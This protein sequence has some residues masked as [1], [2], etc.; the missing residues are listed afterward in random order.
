MSHKL[1]IS[2]NCGVDTATALD[3]TTSFIMCPFLHPYPAEVS[4]LNSC[5]TFRIRIR[6]FRTAHIC[7]LPAI[8]II[9]ILITHAHHYDGVRKQI[10]DLELA[11]LHYHNKEVE[12]C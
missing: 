8:S 1:Q 7:K 6:S 11:S 5:G 2:S 10:V 4:R 12:I 9:N 3:A